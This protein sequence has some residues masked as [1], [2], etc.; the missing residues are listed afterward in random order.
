MFFNV[1]FKIEILILPQDFF[2]HNPI[3]SDPF[4]G[5]KLKKC[6]EIFIWDNYVNCPEILYLYFINLHT[7]VLFDRLSILMYNPQ[8]FRFKSIFT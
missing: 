4:N 7:Y 3:F 1:L 5:E 8:L 2:W 6:N